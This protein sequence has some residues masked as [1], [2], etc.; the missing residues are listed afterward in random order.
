[1]NDKIK[2]ISAFLCGAIFFSGVSFAADT[3]TATSSNLKIIV[4]GRE[5]KLS[6]TPVLIN[7]S[8]YL[9][10]RDVGTITG[11]TV[12]YTKGSVMLNNITASSEPVS[13]SSSSIEQNVIEFKKLPITIEKNGYSVSVDKVS[14]GEISTDIELQIVNNNAQRTTVSYDTVMGSNY[15]VDN[16]AYKAVGDVSLVGKEKFPREIDGNSTTKGIISKGS[17]PVGTHNI[18]F[19]VE[20]GSESFSFYID[21]VGIL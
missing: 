20:V 11:Y 1:M 17:V 8:T 16:F 10:V 3:L 4:N 15:R 21:T 7:G 2:I 14:A 18:L 5:A 19:H 12:D 9:P 13:N 6:K